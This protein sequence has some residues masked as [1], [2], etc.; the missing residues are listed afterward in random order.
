MS[1]LGCDLFGCSNVL[2]SV[3]AEL[4]LRADVVR[5]EVTSAFDVVQSSVMLI[6]FLLEQLNEYI[7]SIF[8]TE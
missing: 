4:P 8:Q 5:S 1:A 2:R 6:G 3:A 7:R